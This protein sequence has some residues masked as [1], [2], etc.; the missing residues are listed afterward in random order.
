MI[1][2]ETRLRKW[3]NSLGL[4][5]PRNK[6]EKEN[7]REG[8]EVKALLI[9]KENVL[10]A[11]FGTFKFKKPVEEIMREIDKELYNE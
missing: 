3:G 8:L 7:M 5:I 1:E 2:V 11:T 4:V 10:R 9:K 6:A